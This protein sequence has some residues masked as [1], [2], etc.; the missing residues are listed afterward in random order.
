MD[1]LH[2]PYLDVDGPI[3]SPSAQIAR[4]LS[5]DDRT[6]ACQQNVGRWY[7]LVQARIDPYT[8]F[9]F[10]TCSIWCVGIH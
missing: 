7:E 8:P 6:S 2:K 3:S 5:V 10:K 4:C 1:A 9:T